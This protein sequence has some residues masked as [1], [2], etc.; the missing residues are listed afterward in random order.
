MKFRLLF[1]I[2]VPFRELKKESEGYS[3]YEEYFEDYLDGISELLEEA[4][5]N[6]ININ[7]CKFI[8]CKKSKSKK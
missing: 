7:E 3:S 4:L 8:S 6:R 2:D 1:K 5:D